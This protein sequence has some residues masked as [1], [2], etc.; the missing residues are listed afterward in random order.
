VLGLAEGGS[1]GLL[2]LELLL[3]RRTASRGVAGGRE[4]TEG[5][6]GVGE[7]G[8]GGGGVGGGAQHMA[9]VGARGRHCLL[10]E[11]AEGGLELP[12]RGL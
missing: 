4:T 12:V 1:G 11:L 6:E 7:G 8:G 9:D 2:G 3:G 10:E 5:C